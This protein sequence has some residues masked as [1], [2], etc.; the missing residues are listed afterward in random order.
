MRRRCTL[1]IDRNRRLHRGSYGF[2]LIELLVVVAIIAVL[3]SILLP[4]L[5][6]ARKHANQV[7]CASNLR[8]IGVALVQYRQDNRMYFPP[9][10]MTYNDA[11]GAQNRGFPFRLMPYLAKLTSLPTGHVVARLDTGKNGRHLFYCPGARFVTF[12]DYGNGVYPTSPLRYEAWLVG[13][14]WDMC[15]ANYGMLSGLGYTGDTTDEWMKPK[16]W[17]AFPER[18]PIYMDNFR[19]PRMDHS[20]Q[21]V[22]FRHPNNTAN[23]LMG[24]G[25]VAN[26][27]KA[28]VNEIWSRRDM[29]LYDPNLW[30]YAK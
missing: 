8:Q 25:R 27:T 11:G 7:A 4:A 19:E 12:A 17:L 15:I 9:M 20:F 26:L 24:D 16:R 10:Y 14:S 30:R 29:H 22:G 5:S 3:I 28:Q 2:T 18:V 23:A 1:F 13:P 21:F 6:K